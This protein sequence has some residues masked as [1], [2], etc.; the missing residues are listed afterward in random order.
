VNKVKSAELFA[1]RKHSHITRKDGKTPYFNHLQDVVNRLKKLGIEN[2]NIICAGWL[3]DT[4][5]DTDTDFDDIEERFGL[6]VA[7]IVSD[8][9]KDKR[10][11][12]QE[13][14]RKFVKQ[15]Q[16]ASIEAKIIKLCDITSNL[17]DLTNM[18]GSKKK[19][20]EQISNKMEYFA[21]IQYDLIKN[22]K[23]MILP[24]IDEIN[25]ILQKYGISSARYYEPKSQKL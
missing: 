1:K 22:R 9:T 25:S 14:E 17:T 13:R 23:T 3:H 5:E 20:I 10:L 16:S 24:V 2:Q 11:P 21:A 4:I 12:K 15:L 6:K 19:K 18:P 7:N 8:V